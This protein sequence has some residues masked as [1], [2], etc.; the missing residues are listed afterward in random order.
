LGRDVFNIAH[1][2]GRR[3]PH[4]AARM[5]IA[6]GMTIVPAFAA[7]DAGVP[8]IPVAGVPTATGAAPVPRDQ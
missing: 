3:H 6:A 2:D 4:A 7:D 8:M 5:D 1:R